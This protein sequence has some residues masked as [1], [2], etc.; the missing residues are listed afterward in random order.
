M[1]EP[2]VTTPTWF[3]SGPTMQTSLVPRHHT[4]LPDHMTVAGESLWP[5]RGGRT[6]P[7]SV[8]NFRSAIGV[9]DVVPLRQTIPSEGSMCGVL[10]CP[11]PLG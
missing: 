6:P 9:A 10:E 5:E 1:G 2:L 3:C 11:E 8:F 7:C 4:G